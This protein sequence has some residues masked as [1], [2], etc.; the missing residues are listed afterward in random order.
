[1]N[2]AVK[3][4]RKSGKVRTKATL[5]TKFKEEK[6][7]QESDAKRR[8]EM[9][10]GSSFAKKRSA[11]AQEIADTQIAQ[12]KRLLGVTDVAHPDY[13][14]LLYRLSDHFLEKKAYFETQSGARYD[15]IYQAQ[16]AKQKS[17]ADQLKAK[18]AKF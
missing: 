11:V 2:S 17:K 14:D 4:N 5:D 16:E 9:M 18:Q 3:Y 12:L 8:V 7:R 15:P 13:P 6:Q 1:T 10:E